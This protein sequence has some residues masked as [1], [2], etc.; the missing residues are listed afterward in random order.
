MVLVIVFIIFIFLIFLASWII[1]YFSLYRYANKDFVLNNDV[2]SRETKGKRKRPNP[3]VKWLDNHAKQINIKSDDGINLRGYI[4][5]ND[6]KDWVVLVHGFSSDHTHM[7]N[8]GIK[9]YNMGFNILLVDLRA[10]GD[11]EG[12]FITMGIKDSHDIVKWCKYITKKEHARSIGL[13]GVSMGAATVMMASGLDLPRTTKYIIE[14]CGYTSVWEELKYQL[15]NIFH[16]PSFPFL[17]I[18]NYYA[19]KIAKFDFKENSPIESLSKTPLPVLMIHGTYDAFVPYYMLDKNYKAC[20]S[21]KEKFVVDKANHT[22]AEDLDYDN[23]WKTIK[24]FIY[25]YK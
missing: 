2:N 21:E 13:F 11:S 7:I 25:K 9:F 23:Y 24:K 17:N 19:K 16:F 6:S 1:F 10:H 4:V 14:D 12:K 20:K 5:N 18:C 3:R 8:R 22:E 15:K